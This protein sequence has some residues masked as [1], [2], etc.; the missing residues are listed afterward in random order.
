MQGRSHAVWAR[1]HVAAAI[2]HA[3]AR[4]GTW[5]DAA[6]YGPSPPP[7]RRSRAG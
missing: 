6:P 5:L 2:A 7:R 1:L 3:G 4:M